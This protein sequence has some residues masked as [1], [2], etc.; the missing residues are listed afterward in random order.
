MALQFNVNEHRFAAV[1]FPSGGIDP[2]SST[3]YYT[4]DIVGQLLD[5]QWKASAIG[6][7]TLK[8]SG[9]DITLWQNKA[10]SGAS[11][12]V[13][14]PGILNQIATGSIA[15]GFIDS[16]YLCEPLYLQFDIGS[17]TSANVSGTSFQVN[18]RYR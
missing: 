16:F 4:G 11:W 12:Q 3:K 2:A 15:G 14:H 5:V 13:V 6:S 8:T 9:T 1:I 18:V 10:P 17:N 7:L